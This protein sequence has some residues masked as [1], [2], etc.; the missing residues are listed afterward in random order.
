M[1]GES[2]K[3]GTGRYTSR[4]FTRGGTT[5]VSKN[6]EDDDYQIIDGVRTLVRPKPLYPRKDDLLTKIPEDNQQSQ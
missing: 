4:K 2:R 1:A 6:D 5:T 3:T